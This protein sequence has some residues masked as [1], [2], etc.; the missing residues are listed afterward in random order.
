MTKRT[1]AFLLPLVIIICL[2]LY[3]WYVL[4]MNGY[5]LQVSHYLALILFI[6]VLYCWYIDKT[7]KK[8]LIATGIYLLLATINVVSLTVGILTSFSF[9]IG[10]L[11][12]WT[13]AFNP[14]G[15]LLLI[16]FGVFNFG[17]LIEMYLDYKESKGKL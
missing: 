11:T 3:S 13:P 1:I 14:F 8:G 2:L 6:P 9:G 12:I 7:L 10:P 4:L 16:I 15:F 5:T 17:S